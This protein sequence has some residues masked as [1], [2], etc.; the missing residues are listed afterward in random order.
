MNELKGK[1][2]PKQKV[3]GKINSSMI[4][5]D[6]EDLEVTPSGQEQNFKSS[7]YGYDNVKVKAV[8]SEELTITPN[9]EEQ[10][11]EGMFN[12]VIVQP[13]ENIQPYINTQNELLYHQAELLSM[14]KMM[15]TQ[16]GYMDM[17]EVINNE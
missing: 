10:V 3:V 1:I 17:L 6:L 5:P 16:L 9:T 2:T 8:E 7:K 15:L 11:K 14:T 12:K 4:Y 13:I